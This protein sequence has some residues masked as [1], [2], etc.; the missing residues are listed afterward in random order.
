LGNLSENVH[1]FIYKRKNNSGSISIIVLKKQRRS[2]KVVSYVGTANN[3]YELEYLIRVAKKRISNIQGE[4]LSIFDNQT[5]AAKLHGFLKR[6][7]PKHAIRVGYYEV[8]GKVFDELQ[9]NDLVK[10]SLFKNLIIA[11]I[12]KPNSKLSTA[13]WLNDKLQVKTNSD[14]IYRLM[15]EIDYLTQRQ[16]NNHLY[17]YVKDYLNDEIHVIFFDATTLHFETFETDSFRS[18][19]YSKV[20]KHNQPQIVVG[21]MV[22]REGLPLGYEVFPGNKW[23]GHTIVSALTRVKRRSGVNRVVFVADAGMSTEK[24]IALIEEFGYEFILADKLKSRS[25]QIKEYVL[26]PKN[27]NDQDICEMVIGARNHKLISHYSED[28]ARKDRVDRENV[29][30][31]TRKKISRKNRITKS[32]IRAPKY[33]D[34]IGQSN[35][36]LNREKVR[37]DQRW[38]GIKGYR[39]NIEDLPAIDIIA[40]YHDLW[41]VERAFK[42][43]KQDLGIRPIHHRKRDRIRAH[44]FL[45]FVSLVVSRM[46]ELKVKDIKLTTARMLE[47]LDSVQENI[48]KDS[49]TKEEFRFRPELGE[50]NK[51]IYE[52]LNIPYQ[53]GIQDLEREV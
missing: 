48:F 52:R 1:V 18:L 43:T 37:N 47:H 32:V 14:Q 7:I 41:Q 24:N 4:Q 21:L 15:D 10:S 39:T 29:I 35:L 22:T 2:N 8:F 16:I 31:R 42:V 53:V 40:R 38:D 30:E 45:V 50:I 12:A 17:Q 9:L 20:G 19:G 44:I 23:D 13:R 46:V 34:L 11:R 5:A 3:E 51:G 25:D 6:F 36:V 28:R 26:D 49:I 33:F 27:Y